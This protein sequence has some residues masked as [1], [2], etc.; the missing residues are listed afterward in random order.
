MREG[1]EREGEKRR[2]GAKPLKNLQTLK[3]DEVRDW[4]D[5]IRKVGGTRNGLIN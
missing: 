2:G 3:G 5:S 4:G 1:R